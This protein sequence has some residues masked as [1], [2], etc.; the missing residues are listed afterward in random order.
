MSQEAAPGSRRTVHQIAREVGI[1]PTSLAICRSPT[2]VH[3]I[4]R[5]DLKL[6]SVRKRRVL[7]NKLKLTR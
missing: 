4:V 2:T 5:R 1:I 3:D 6:K 7:R